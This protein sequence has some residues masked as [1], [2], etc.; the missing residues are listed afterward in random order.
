MKLESWLF[1]LAVSVPRIVVGTSTKTSTESPDP[2]VTMKIRGTYIWK[3]V[4]DFDN[5][6][7]QA[8]VDYS[9]K[10]TESGLYNPGTFNYA[11]MAGVRRIPPD[12]SP[13][14]PNVSY[15]PVSIGF[16]D[17]RDSNKD[18]YT[19]F[20]K[21][22]QEQKEEID[23]FSKSHDRK[24]TIGAGSR[25]ILYQ[26]AFELPGVMVRT[27][28]FQWTS[29]PLPAK[30]VAEDVAIKMVMAPRK[31]LKD[32]KVVCSNIRGD[33]PP[34]RVR[35]W[36]GGTTNINDT[37]GGKFCWIVPVMT[38]NVNE[39]QTRVELSLPQKADPRYVNLAQGTKGSQIYLHP[40][41]QSDKDLFITEVILARFDSD[42]YS[43]LN[44]TIW[45]GLP[46][47]Y[48][49]NINRKREARGQYLYLV[50]RL[51]RTYM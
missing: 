22:A 45:P 8:S 50:W 36:F 48:T 12:R 51:E 49:R 20:Q 5:S 14:K 35:D 17:R 7:N 28:Y 31:Y 16:N 15:G 27:D 1:T 18:V 38:T 41:R 30:S 37:Y 43:S 19:V 34:D 26:R 3:M 47:G 11:F 10:V 40:I 21:A 24:H 33:A 23:F 4:F 39:A 46:K 9:Y 42:K 2:R 32:L 29:N 13:F 6:N 25:V 44:N